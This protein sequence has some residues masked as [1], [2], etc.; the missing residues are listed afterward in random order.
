M[1]WTELPMMNFGRQKHACGLTRD[2]KGLLQIR[3]VAGVIDQS[4]TTSSTVE[5]LSLSP[6]LA[7]Q[8]KISPIQLTHPLR[9]HRAVQFRDH[10]VVVSG[11]PSGKGY[12]NNILVVSANNSLI[13][14]QQKVSYTRGMFL[15]FLLKDELVSCT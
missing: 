2:T 9:A 12:S 6:E 4:S 13:M 8:W 14:K 3:A 5:Y 11:A 1:T 10:F 7:S 15:P